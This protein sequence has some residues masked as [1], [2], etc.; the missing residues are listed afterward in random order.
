MISGVWHAHTAH[1]KVKPTPCAGA[2]NAVVGNT[3]YSYGGMNSVSPYRMVDELYKLNIEAMRWRRVE[4]EGTKP[5]VRC[6]A[7]MCCVNR[8]LIMMGGYGP[9]TS[10][11]RHS[12]AEYKE[13][14]S[15]SSNG[16][17]N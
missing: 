8:K 3:I 13:N 4:I 12:Q 2:C 15:T 6:G 14:T 16:C 11:R 17:N 9:M 5:T 7:A 1:A 10:Y